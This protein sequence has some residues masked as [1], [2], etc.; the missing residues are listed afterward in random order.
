MYSSTVRSLPTVPNLN[1]TNISKEKI[2]S[3]VNITHKMVIIN[4]GKLKKNK[5]HSAPAVLWIRILMTMASWIRTSSQRCA[6][7]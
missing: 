4:L 6:V 1:T 3:A 2:Y 7:M 5:L